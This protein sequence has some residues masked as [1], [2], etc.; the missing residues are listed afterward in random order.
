MADVRTSI[1]AGKVLSACL[2]PMEALSHNNFTTTG[3]AQLDHNLM[4]N[5]THW[6][7]TGALENGFDALPEWYQYTGGS[8]RG[9]WQALYKDII[10]SIQLAITDGF[11]ASKLFMGIPL[12][13]YP[14]NK[15]I[16]KS[17]KWIVDSYAADGL[18]LTD[19]IDE[20]QGANYGTSY[21]TPWDKLGGVSIYNNHIW[22]NT[23]IR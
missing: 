11:S 12:I 16:W 3:E 17:W 13:F 1:G 14:D 9:S 20:W 18:T 2:R 7:G 21:A 19:N 22:F 10:I 23:L 5:Y 8:I 6:V 15:G 4:M